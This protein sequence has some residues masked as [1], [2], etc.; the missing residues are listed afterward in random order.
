MHM[1]VCMQSY[2]QKIINTCF[3]EYI[4]HIQ[5]DHILNQKARLNKKQSNKITNAIN[6]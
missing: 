2:K 3:Q 5:G 1:S 4:E 6:A